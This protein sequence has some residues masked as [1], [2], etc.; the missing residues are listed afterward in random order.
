MSPRVLFPT[1]TACTVTRLPCRTRRAISLSVVGIVGVGL[2]VIVVVVV[3]AFRHGGRL[4]IATAIVGAM[5][6][7]STA[8]CVCGLFD[9]SVVVNTHKFDHLAKKLG[10]HSGRGGTLKV[11]A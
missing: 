6:G 9:N 10:G 11:T 5:V 3:R 2:V 7:G 1:P 8:G 4:M